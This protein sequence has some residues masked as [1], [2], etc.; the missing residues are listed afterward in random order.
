MD[1]IA[2]GHVMH[3]VIGLLAAWYPVWAFGADSGPSSDNLDAQARLAL[4]D[5]L[6]VAEAEAPPLV[7]VADTSHRGVVYAAHT[8]R[9][10]LMVELG[11][12][13]GALAVTWRPVEGAMPLSLSLPALEAE[14]RRILS[15]RFPS[16]QDTTDL[17][18][19]SAPGARLG[20]LVWR[21][22]VRPGVLT[23]ESAVVMFRTDLGEVTA[24]Y[25]QRSSQR[26]S[27]ADIRVGEDEAQERAA[28]IAVA[29]YPSARVVTPGTCVLVLSS[30]LQGNHGPV[31]EVMFRA[32]GEGGESQGP[33]VTV[34]L[35][36]MT[37]AEIAPR[38]PL[39]PRGRVR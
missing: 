13:E 23:G 26:T 7:R 29:R 18:E 39:L 27:E 9:H 4:A 35:D 3:M 14:A 30:P 11:P 25:E 1:R 5:V 32:Q 22:Q 2:R 16:V 10:R 8:T 19:G 21:D 38:P 15:A 17:Q 28:R 6:G 12:V 24:Y 20:Y 36:A 37:G 33:T 31:W 34:V